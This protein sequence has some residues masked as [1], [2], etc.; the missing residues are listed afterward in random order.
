MANT[1][2]LNPSINAFFSKNF[3]LPLK[4]SQAGRESELIHAVLTPG[5]GTVMGLRRRLFLW[6]AIPLFNLTR[7]V[8]RGL[9]AIRHPQT[10]YKSRS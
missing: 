10:I 5:N 9:R 3:M 8:P 4:N 6:A 7:T 2:R 1:I